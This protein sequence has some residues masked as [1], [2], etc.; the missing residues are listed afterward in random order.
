MTR[1]AIPSLFISHAQSFVKPRTGRWRDFVDQAAVH[2]CLESRDPDRQMS[3]ERL[4]IDLA[5]FLNIDARQMN[6]NLA[7][8][9]G[10]YEP[11]A[12]PEGADGAEGTEG[13]PA[14]N[15][16]A[17]PRLE[18]AICHL[19]SGTARRLPKQ[20]LDIGYAIPWASR[21]F[22]FGFFS[23]LLWVYVSTMAPKLFARQPLADLPT[24]LPTSLTTAAA[25]TPA[26]LVPTITPTITINLTST[27]TIRLGLEDPTNVAGHFGGFLSDKAQNS[28]P[29]AEARK[30]A[31]SIE[32]HGSNEILVKVPAGTKTSWLAKGAID[33]DVWRGTEM[34]KSKLS[35]TDEG[36]VIEISKKDA[37]GVMN[38]SVVTSRRPK[39]NET[40]AVNF[41]KPVMAQAF[42]VGSDLVAGVARM[43]AQ[44]A[45][46]AIDI[47]PASFVSDRFKEVGRAAH[48]YS[49]DV[50]S[51]AKNSLTTASLDEV[52]KRAQAQAGKAR[53]RIM[54]A[55][56]LLT[57]QIRSTQHVSDQLRLQVEK[58]QISSRLLWLKMQKKTAEHASYQAKALVYIHEKA[59]AIEEK[60]RAIKEK[61]TSLEKKLGASGQPCRSCK[62]GRPGKW[63]R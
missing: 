60:A 21:P 16:E 17:A 20:V 9:T 36:I 11:L 30:M 35:T 13:E 50:A 14:R 47:F 52:V 32:I 39:I 42:E 37:Y 46:G 59:R 54:E 57:Q 31:C 15:A 12:T 53:D 48:G 7:Y 6:R 2:M 5:S 56:T 1:H 8:L 33:I 23:T 34:L 49:E 26:C 61:R 41:G 62:A 4:P 19:L 29:E 24:A 25:V 51:R 58:A 18:H 55:Q 38:V 27:K 44:A 43:I 22:L 10:L 63:V 3:P 40:F 28:A 45:K